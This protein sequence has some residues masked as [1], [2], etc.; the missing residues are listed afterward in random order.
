VPLSAKAAG[1]SLADLLSRIYTESVG[2][3]HA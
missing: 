2:V 1:L 3:R